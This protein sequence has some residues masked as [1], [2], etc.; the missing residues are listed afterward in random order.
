MH[1]RRVGPVQWQNR[2]ESRPMLR[3]EGLHRPN[4]PPPEWPDD[5]DPR[6]DCPPAPPGLIVGTLCV[7]LSLLVLG[8]MATACFHNPDLASDPAFLGVAVLALVVLVAAATWIWFT[9]GAPRR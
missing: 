9:A 8:V 1:A 2:A 4:T 7:V 6:H 3:A 5:P